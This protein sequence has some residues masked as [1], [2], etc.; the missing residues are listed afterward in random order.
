MVQNLVVIWKQIKQFAT[1]KMKKIHQIFRPQNVFFIVYRKGEVN[2]VVVWRGLPGL[3]ALETPSPVVGLPSS[4]SGT[5]GMVPNKCGPVPAGWLRLLPEGW[6]TR[7]PS[8]SGESRHT[9]KDSSANRKLVFRDVLGC[10][11]W[12]WWKEGVEVEFCSAACFGLV[13]SN[14]KADW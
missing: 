1:E 12:W 7:A 10:R 5:S 3:L 9:G 13:C 8:S 2:L 14:S 4:S 11:F 6:S